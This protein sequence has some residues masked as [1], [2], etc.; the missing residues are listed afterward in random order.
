MLPTQNSYDNLSRSEVNV[1]AFVEERT[2]R[3]THF[4]DD[5]QHYD[6]EIAN[7]LFDMMKEAGC[8]D[9][10]KL[11][12]K[13]LNKVFKLAAKLAAGMHGV[14]R[15]AK[16]FQKKVTHMKQGYTTDPAKF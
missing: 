9:S 3:A 6:K 7:I 16:R 13:S 8:G 1:V 11:E 10:K 2:S 12:T 5:T 15:T 14:K 4:G